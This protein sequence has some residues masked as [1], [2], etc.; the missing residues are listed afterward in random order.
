VY[1]SRIKLDITNR[2]TQIALVSPNKFHGA[3]EEAFRKRQDRNLWRIDYLKNQAYLL[4]L[5][6]EEPQLENLIQQFG[7]KDDIGETK[8][9]DKLI[10]SISK[11]SKWRFRLIANPTHSEKKDGERGKVVA[12]V[13]EKYQLEWLYKKAEENGFVINQEETQLVASGW[14]SFYK[15]NNKSKVVIKE[16]IFEGV[17]E[18][19]NAEK[20]KNAL[21][22]GIGRE[23]AYGMGLI[24]IVRI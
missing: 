24:T 6:S 8:D 5:S 12:H 11:G 2:R 16:A 13:S 19:E 1:L 21:I 7:F 20:F 9:Y 18:I 14:K 22:N 4:I 10:D 3:I 15:K 23:K 17:I